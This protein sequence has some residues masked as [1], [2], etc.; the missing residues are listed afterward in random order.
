MS[1][2]LVNRNSLAAISK[3]YWRYIQTTLLRSL[4]PLPPNKFAYELRPRKQKPS[5]GFE[6]TRRIS[7]NT[8]KILR[9]AQKMLLTGTY[10][11]GLYGLMMSG[12]RSTG[13]SYPLE[14]MRRVTEI[15]TFLHPLVLPPTYTESLSATVVASSSVGGG[16]ESSA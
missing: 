1:L 12:E 6:T 7:E 14:A 3:R 9:V 8:E 10:G 13:M 16:T 15:F 4:P 11:K 2:C 5:T